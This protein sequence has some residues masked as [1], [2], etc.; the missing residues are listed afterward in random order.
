MR[1]A[2]Y[3]ASFV[4]I[5]CVG[6]LGWAAGCGGSSGDGT[7]DAGK[8]GTAGG[9]SGG[10]TLG[11]GS[12]GNGIPATTTKD[13]LVSTSACSGQGTTSISGKVF[14]PA[15]KNPV[16]NVAVWVP[17]TKPSP[18]PAGLTCNCSELYTGGFVGQYAL[19]DAT[20]AFTISPAPAAKQAGASVPLV[21]QIGKWRTQTET[22]VSCGVDNK[23]PDG[24][25]RLPG[26]LPTTPASPGTDPNGQ[27][28]GDL[29]SLAISTGGADTLEC[30]LTRI[31]VSENEYAAGA[32]TSK[33]I[34]IFQGSPDTSPTMVGAPLSY[35]SLWDK[36]ADLAAYD[37][38]LLSCEG[39]P[40]TNLNAASLFSYAT[41]GGRVFAS[42]YHYQWFLGTPWPTNP[43]LGTWY[44]TNPNQLNN[45]TFGIIPTT[46]PNGVPF[47]QGQAMKTWLG[48][49][50][51]LETNGELQIVQARHNVDVA[52]GQ[53]G[54]PWMY[55]DPNGATFVN[56]A[57][58]T[59]DPVTAQSTLYFSYDTM[60]AQ[61]EG[62]CGRIVYSDLHV[63]GNSGDYGESA[64]S[65]SPPGGRTDV[66]T[67]CNAVVDL[68]K[69][70]KALEFM[71]FDLTS[72]LAPPGSDAG[73]T[74]GMAQ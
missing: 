29:P 48:A 47:P 74:I 16:Y 13:G 59:N 60:G 26:R 30:L 43:P 57:T 12:G 35:A 41:M 22:T 25:L 68:S 7:S 6:L 51:A 2:R 3:V 67:G 19:T 73:V 46:L 71:L 70:E 54:V 45:P 31:G 72:C 36:A 39:A 1:T 53:S 69:Q 61:G 38:V 8:D 14:D 65:S 28:T 49:V 62:S 27:V 33:Q 66:P 21:L 37:A 63:G 20:G 58:S 32:S 44:T 24:T 18:M 5:A 23:I 15:G 11:D 17:Y 40:T 50:N 34:H 56:G 9:G 42:H 52:R 10:I 64:N 4:V 55:F